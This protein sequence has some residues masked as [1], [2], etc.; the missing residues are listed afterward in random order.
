MSLPPPQKL[1]RRGVFDMIIISS[2][3]KRMSE[4]AGD[5]LCDQV[6]DYHVDILGFL[7]ILDVCMYAVVAQFPQFPSAIACQ[8][9]DLATDSLGILHGFDDVPGVPAS[10]YRDY[11]VIR[12]QLP[13]QLHREYVLVSAIVGDGHHR[14]DVVVETDESEL[15]VE[16]YGCTLVEVAHD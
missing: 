16:V 7:H 5:Y 11:Q 14:G 6:V 1:M 15:P 4:S 10:G 12:L 9:D 2:S 13:F 8:S 3:A